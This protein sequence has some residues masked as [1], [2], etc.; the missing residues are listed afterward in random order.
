MQSLKSP[1]PL[2]T[3]LARKEFQTDG[4]TSLGYLNWILA[5]LLDKFAGHW[6]KRLKM[7]C[8]ECMLGFNNVRLNAPF[9]RVPD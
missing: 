7:I 6:Q 3:G 5:S 1:S 4:T 9:G 8:V 2:P